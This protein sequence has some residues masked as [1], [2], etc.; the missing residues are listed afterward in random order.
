MTWAAWE[1]NC[2]KCQH[3]SALR[4]GKLEFDER[5][6]PEDTR[7]RYRGRRISP[8]GVLE[9]MRSDWRCPSREAAKAGAR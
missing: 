1:A 8:Q 4:S 3:H 9:R 2:L 5:P 6:C 7:R